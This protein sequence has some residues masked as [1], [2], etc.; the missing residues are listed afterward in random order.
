VVPPPDAASSLRDIWRTALRI[1]A[2]RPLV[3]LLGVI[4][5]VVVAI[6]AVQAYV[7]I[8]AEIPIFDP[9]VLWLLAYDFLSV[10]SQTV[11]CL[12]ASGFVAFLLRNSPTGEANGAQRIPTAAF[13]RFC[14]VGWFL[15]IASTGL[16]GYPEALLDRLVFLMEEPSALVLGKFAVFAFSLAMLRAGLTAAIF[17]RLPTHGSRDPNHLR[18]SGRLLF[19]ACLAVFEV[20]VFA[21]LAIWLIWLRSITWSQE[22]TIAHAAIAITAA[23]SVLL[24]FT[25]HRRSGSLATVFD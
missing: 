22:L 11:L 2:Q 25:V 18:R 10:I 24:A 1:P 12:G 9:L 16:F 14:V 13:L 19:W 3:T 4:V 23:L 17:N 20:S 5:A 7:T 21:Q 15:V 6:G 8:V